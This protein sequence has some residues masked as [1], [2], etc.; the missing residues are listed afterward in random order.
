M[1]KCGDDIKQDHLVLQMFKIFE[2]LWADKGFD[3]KMNI[4]KVMSTGN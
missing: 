4:Y 2:K 1:Y 3:F